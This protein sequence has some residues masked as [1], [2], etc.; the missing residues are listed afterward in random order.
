M[1]DNTNN[2]EFW[3]HYV[4]YWEDKVE[5]ANKNKDAPDRT[6]DDILLEIFWERLETK[7]EEMVLDYG[8]GSG[9]LYPIYCRNLKWGDIQ[10]YGIDV[11]GVSLEHARR[12]Y[13]E[14]QLGENLIEFDGER[15]PFKKNCFDKIVCFS[16]FDAV[17]QEVVLAELLR[18][19]KPGGKLLLTGKN[20]RYFDN[21]EDAF[22]AEVNAR[23]KEHPNSFT[24]VEYLEKQL[25]N[26]GVEIC[27]AFYFLKRRD[28]ALN[29]YICDLPDTFYQWA[30]IMKKISDK[31]EFTFHNFS[32][33]YSETF[34]KLQKED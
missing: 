10:Y 24:D 23:K 28:F 21:D 6:A 31:S 32:S 18:V 12:R 34:R 8:C 33:H 11:S 20:T 3:N 27:D 29:Q 26:Y 9:R 30:L 16:V 13:P 15:I 25:T 2:K 22:I 4:S 17:R 7:P 5:E 14:L 19:L 1:K